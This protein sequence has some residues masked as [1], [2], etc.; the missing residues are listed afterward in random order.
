MAALF[1]GEGCI[2]A[3]KR[4]G[5]L[6]LQFAMTDLDVLETFQR[7]AGGGWLSPRPY[8]K[9]GLGKK[10]CWELRFTG[11]RAYALVIAMWPWMHERRR[12]QITKAVQRWLLAVP[13]SAGIKITREQV[14][15]IKRSLALD[16]GYGTSRRLAEKYGVSDALIGAIKH[17][18]VWKGVAA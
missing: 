2:L 10:P 7:M 15:E 6:S 14:G 9:G 8:D 13:T 1:E 16:S 11:R 17:G 18:R 3:E 4:S 5:K 12:G